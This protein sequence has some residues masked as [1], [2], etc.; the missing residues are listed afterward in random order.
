MMRSAEDKELHQDERDQRRWRNSEELGDQNILGERGQTEMYGRDRGDPTGQDD[1]EIL[2]DLPGVVISS[3][4]ED[5][6]FVQQK[7]A[8]NADKIRDGNCDERPEEVTQQPNG[9]EVH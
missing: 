8:S 7:V 9:A 5:P 6:E 1:D 2:H 3:A 4:P